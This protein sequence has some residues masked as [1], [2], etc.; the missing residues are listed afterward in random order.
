MSG[1]PQNH[2]H[3]R[4]HARRAADRERR[5]P[6]RSDKIRLLDALSETGSEGDRGGLLREPQ[7]DAA[8][9]RDGRAGPRFHPSR[10]SATP[11]RRSTTG[12]WSARGIYAAALEPHAPVSTRVTCAT[13]SRSATPTGR[14]RRRSRAGRRQSKGRS[15]QARRRGGIGVNAGLGLQLDRRVQ[16]RSSACTCSTAVPAVGRGGHPRHARGSGGSDGLEHAPPGGAARSATIKERWPSITDFNLHLHNGRGMALPSAYAALRVLDS[17]RHAAPAVRDRRHGRLPYCGNGRAADDD[18]H[19]G[20]DAHAGGHGHSHRRRPLQ[21]DRGGLA[22]GGDRRPSAVRLCLQG[23]PAS[24]LRPAVRD[25]HAAHRDA[26]AGAS[27][28]SRARSVCAAPLARGRRRS[29]AGSGPSHYERKRRRTEQ[30]LPFRARSDRARHARSQV[31]RPRQNAA[32]RGR[33]RPRAEPHRRRPERRRHLGDLGADVIKIEHPATGDTARSHS[34]AGQTFYSF[35]RNKKYLAL[36]LRKRRRQ[37][38]FRSSSWQSSDVVLDNFAPGSFKRL[39]LDYEWGQGQ[40]AHHLLLG[41][42]FPARPVQR[43]AFSRRAWRR[44]PAASR[45]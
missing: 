27:T 40:S 19:R 16:P 44:W 18:R 3:R 21:A 12:A 7:V 33:A 36:D 11:T 6:G 45:T 24:A 31:G 38:N 28:S 26:G 41:Q 2:P 17:T 10:A 13:S 34:N 23:G 43:P 14:R 25:G 39:G 5:H 32:A 37:E 30:R 42:R 29:R 22:R 4:G 8:D 20:P 9:G 35:N 1:Y 15:E